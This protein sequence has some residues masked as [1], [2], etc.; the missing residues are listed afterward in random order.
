[1]VF[2]IKV[3]F[4]KMSLGSSVEMVEFIKLQEEDISDLY[5]RMQAVLKDIFKNL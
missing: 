5:F 1:M 4:L 3:H 2:R